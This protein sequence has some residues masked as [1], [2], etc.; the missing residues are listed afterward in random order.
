MSIEKIE[1]KDIDLVKATIAMLKL[2]AEKRHN[3]IDDYIEWSKYQE[4]INGFKN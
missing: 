4:I 3:I 1:V 2:G